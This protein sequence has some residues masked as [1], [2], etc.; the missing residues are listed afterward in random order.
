MT[1]ESG[2]FSCKCVSNFTGAFCELDKIA[3][4]CLN[5]TC[6]GNGFCTRT[7]SGRAAKCN[8]YTGYKGRRCNKL[9]DLCA[10]NGKPCLYDHRCIT[11]TTT[12]LC[13]SDFWGVQCEYT[14]D[15]CNL[16]SCETGQVCVHDNDTQTYTCM[17][18]RGYTGE[19]C[20]ELIDYCSSQPCRNNATCV[21]HP[22]KMFQCF[23]A[24]G[25]EGRKC[26]NRIVTC[27]ENM[28][29]NN[30]TCEMVEPAVHC[31]CPPNYTGIFCETYIGI[32]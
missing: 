21:N 11:N 30:G 7:N 28:C 8:C 17:C 20:T 31:R 29:L 22:Q 12:C 14:N 15:L 6:N 25:Y 24:V 5:E 13:S 32:E 19:N 18:P 4:P 9:S 27:S 10:L 1:S 23:C 26:K 3:D 2:S 16:Y